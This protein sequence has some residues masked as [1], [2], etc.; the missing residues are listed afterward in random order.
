MRDQDFM[1]PKVVS[2]YVNIPRVLCLHTISIWVAQEIV[3]KV[4][5]RSTIVERV[6][7]MPLDMLYPKTDPST[8]DSKS[9]VNLDVAKWYTNFLGANYCIRSMFGSL[10]R[11]FEKYRHVEL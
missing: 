10:E 3:G 9:C 5:L 6:Y 4:F 7:T 1:N 2:W 8:L 11:L